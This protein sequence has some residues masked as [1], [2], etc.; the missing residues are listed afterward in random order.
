MIKIAGALE[1]VYITP[2][3]LKVKLNE[4]IDATIWMVPLLFITLIKAPISILA[5]HRNYQRPTQFTLMWIFIIGCILFTYVDE[6]PIRPDIYA[7]DHRQVM[8]WIGLLAFCF[9]DVANEMISVN[10]YYYT[11]FYLNVSL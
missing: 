6:F 11:Q 4:W 3:F 7:E 1:I 5:A 9:I 8:T 10:L 2:Y